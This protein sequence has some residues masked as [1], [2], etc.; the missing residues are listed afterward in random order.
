[1][2]E[3]LTTWRWMLQDSQWSFFIGTTKPWRPLLHPT[4][5]CIFLASFLGSPFVFAPHRV[6][7]VKNRE[8]CWRPVLSPWVIKADM[9]WESVGLFVTGPLGFHPKFKRSGFL[10]WQFYWSSLIPLLD[11]P[12]PWFMGMDVPMGKSSRKCLKAATRS[13]CVCKCNVKSE[14]HSD[15][16]TQWFGSVVAEAKG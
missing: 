10:L 11:S 9:P 8:V 4:P 14:G 12:S 16:P 1:M 3:T 6:S 2:A 15:G 5:W 7:W 13:H